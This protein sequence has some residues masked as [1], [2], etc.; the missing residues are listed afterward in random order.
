LTVIDRS[1]TT[2]HGARAARPEPRHPRGALEGGGASPARTFDAAVIGAGP[3]GTAAAIALARRGAKVALLEGQP[4]APMR[5]AGEWLHPP[6]RAILESLGVAVADVHG[7]VETGGRGFVVFPSDGS[8]PIRLV[9]GKG[10]QALTAE[11]CEI[12][13]ALRRAAAEESGVTLL[14][15]AVCTSV[16]GGRIDYT[17]PRERGARRIEAD[18]IVGADGRSSFVRR[19]LGL[20][21]AGGRASE[22]KTASYMAGLLLEECELP[23]EGF[24]HVVVGT[25]GPV[26]VY[27]ISPTEARVCV[28]VPVSLARD[29]AT[30]RDAYAPLLPEGLRTP[31]LRSLER[32]APSWAALAVRPRREFGRGRYALVGDAV[33][34]CHPLTAVGM[35]VGLLDAECLAR[36]PSLDAF[37]AERKQRSRVPEALAAGLYELFTRRDPGSEALRGALYDVWRESRTDRVRTMRLLS[38]EDV[39]LMRLRMGLLR[40]IPTA[41]GSLGDKALRSLD[42]RRTK[43]T[44]GGMWRWL[45]WLAEI[46]A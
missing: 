24:G 5:L 45:T 9:Y 30:L 27:R 31:F 10:A 15:A 41:L 34:T 14:P 22:K 35:T 42:L 17:S 1:H 39:Q 26:L 40:V 13:A 36:S 6:G 19:A 4:G 23:F 16:Q 28:D 3:V 11:H 32:R 43:E 38:G 2:F 25:P 21:A 33:G 29:A 46:G 37:R 20:D 7:A 8:A 44:L 12:V 18:V